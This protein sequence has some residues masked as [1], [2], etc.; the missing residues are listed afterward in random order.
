[1]QIC[2]RWP[3]A[4][5]VEMPCLLRCL[6]TAAC[7][8]TETPDST[9]RCGL[10]VITLQSTDSCPVI[11]QYESQMSDNFAYIYILNLE[12]LCRRFCHKFHTKKL[13]LHKKLLLLYNLYKSYHDVNM[14]TPFKSPRLSM[15]IFQFGP[16]CNLLE[17]IFHQHSYSVEITNA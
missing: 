15:L 2:Y 12:A 1:M 17:Y 10:V 6:E 5:V 16:E 13:Q 7:W 3:S 8:Q 9:V 11:V 4:Y 14:A